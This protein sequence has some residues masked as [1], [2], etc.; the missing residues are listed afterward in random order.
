MKGDIMFGSKFDDKVTR[1]NYKH[2]VVELRRKGMTENEIA[3][4]LGLNRSEMSVLWIF[5]DPER[6]PE[7]W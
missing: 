7:Y 5:T 6:H 1:E 4:A 3:D 2:K